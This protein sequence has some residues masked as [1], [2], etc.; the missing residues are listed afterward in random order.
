[1]NAALSPDDERLHRRIRA[2]AANRP[3]GPTPEEL[4][5]EE[6]IKAGRPWPEGPVA[7]LPV[8]QLYVRDVPL[9]R[10]PGQS[11]A[12]LLQVLWCPFDHPEHPATAVFWRS[13]ATV[14]D[15]LAAP[16]EP[17]HDPVLHLSA[18]AVASSHR[19]GSPNTPTIW[20]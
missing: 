12:D 3:S 10:P 9:L 18:G 7:L 13:A 20:S 1:M 2:A 15:L 17:P 5:A 8:A 16:P 11:G 19:S 4:A 14:T 6:R